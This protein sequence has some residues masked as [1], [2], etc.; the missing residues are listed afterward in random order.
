MTH[1]HVREKKFGSYLVAVNP[2]RHNFLLAGQEQQAGPQEDGSN[3]FSSPNIW[4]SYK[5][6]FLVHLILTLSSN[7]APRVR[8]TQGQFGFDW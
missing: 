6:N 1:F 5:F 8:F 7:L 3:F 4:N 2:F